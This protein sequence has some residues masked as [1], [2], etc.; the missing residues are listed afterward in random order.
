LGDKK[1]LHL[2]PLIRKGI[3]KSSLKSGEKTLR[4]KNQILFGQ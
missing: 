4:I 3:G 2:Q 1:G